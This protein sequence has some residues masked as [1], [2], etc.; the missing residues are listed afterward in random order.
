MN[1][2]YPFRQLEEKIQAIRSILGD[3]KGGEVPPPLLAAIDM[4]ADAV[5]LLKE[6]AEDCKS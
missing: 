4:L 3:L 2:A 6:H 1:P 5:E